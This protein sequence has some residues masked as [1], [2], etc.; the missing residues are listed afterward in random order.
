MYF[1]Q[2]PQ[3]YKKEL[4]KA[5]IEIGAD[6]RSLFLYEEYYEMVN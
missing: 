2:D 1:E 4:E 6:T 5:I 3:K